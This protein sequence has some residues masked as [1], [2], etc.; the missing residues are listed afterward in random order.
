MMILST[1]YNDNL[2]KK[3]KLIILFLLFDA[4]AN[5]MVGMGKDMFIANAIF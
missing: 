1:V 3:K 4:A 5:L 2:E